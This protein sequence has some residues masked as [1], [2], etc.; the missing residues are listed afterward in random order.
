MEAP[1]P[2]TSST[3]CVTGAG[4]FLASWL[5]KLLLSKD[6]Y[7]I[8]GT[9]RDLGEGKNAHLKAL[10][11]AGERLRLFKADVLD[12]G[13]VAAAIAGCDGVFHVASPV[14]SGRPTNP[15]VDII[16]TAVTGTLNVLRASHEAKVKRVVVLSVFNNP[17][18]PT[19]EPFNE[20][21]WSDEETCRKNEREA[22]EYAAK[23]GMDI[24]T[25]CPALIMGPLMQPTVPTSIEVFFHIIK[26]LDS[27]PSCPKPGSAPVS[28]AGDN[29]T[30]GN[31][32]ETLLDV[33]DVADALLLVY[34]NSGGS[35]RDICSSTPRKLSDIIN[36]SKSL[37][38]AFNY[39]QKF[40]EVDEEQNTRFS[41]EKLEKLGWTFRPMEETLR[42]SFES[43]IGLGILT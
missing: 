20:D 25:I 8:N 11:N 23:T 24:V 33:R 31:R 30:V 4:G 38:P 29:E 42:D 18:W 16:A 34:E 21:S 32:L 7:V 40:V 37:Y 22:F 36:T 1:P 3:V 43:Y 6:H 5:V 27:R 26:V 2:A 17:N 41:S 28:N 12:Y 35:E 14:T 39:P 10:E 13:S 9:V 15:E 19:G